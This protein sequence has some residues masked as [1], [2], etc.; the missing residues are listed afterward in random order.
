ML[1]F[2]IFTMQDVQ[3]LEDTVNENIAKGYLPFGSI[4]RTDRG[5]WG[6]AMIKKELVK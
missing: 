3:D 1:D 5:A 6:I 4:F 2:F